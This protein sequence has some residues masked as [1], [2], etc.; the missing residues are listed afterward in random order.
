ML[1]KTVDKNISIIKH[2]FDDEFE[3]SQRDKYF[4]L[5]LCGDE[6]AIEINSVADVIETV[7]TVL[8]PVEA[9]GTNLLIE[10]KCRFIPAVSLRKIL[11]LPEA[12]DQTAIIITISQTQRAL[13]VDP[14]I[15]IEDI[16]IKG[17]E[18]IVPAAAGS[19]G[20]Y[21]KAACRVNGV[22]KNILDIEK[23]FSI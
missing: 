16:D 20:D 11:N 21:I 23:I 12:K 19:G 4:V 5:N 14:V 18:K 17:T 22:V 2:E 6:Y 9:P 8:I 3:N 10:H 7:K 1:M 15:E 13:I